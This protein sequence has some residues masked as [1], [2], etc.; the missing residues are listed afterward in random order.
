[1]GT[2]RC[3]RL[4]FLL[5]S[6]LMV[7]LI[8]IYW[9]DVGALNLYPHDPHPHPT[10]PSSSPSRPSSSS[11]LSHPLGGGLLSATM[12]VQGTPKSPRTT[13]PDRPGE[14]RRGTP[15]PPG[16]EHPLTQG[17]D[18]SELEERWR[19]KEREEERMREEEGK[20]EEERVRQVEEEEKREEEGRRQEDR[21]RRIS[22]MCSGNGTL[23]FPGKFRTFDQIPNRELDHLIVDDRHQIIYCYVPKVACTNWKRV[24]VVLSEGLLAP[25]GRPYR[26]PQALPPDLIH[27]SSLHL[28]FSKFWRRYGRLSR[29]LMR[30]KLQSY[31]KFLFVRDPFVRLISAFRNKFQQPNEDFYRQFGSVMLRRYGN[32]NGTS[33]V[34]ESAAEAF[35]AGIHPSFS[36]FVRYLLDPQT[37]QEQ[38]F[39]EHW[40]QVYRLCHPCQIQYDFIGTL[41]NLED[42]SDQLLRILGL[43]DQIK[44]PPSNRNR[45]AASWERDWFTEVP[46]ELRRKLY[47][48]YQPDFE[49][50]GYPKP[51]SLL[52]H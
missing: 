4:A 45:T 29:H 14:G 52:H 40:R 31:T 39:N 23:Q 3:F 25:D 33:R 51:E 2:S 8:I 22:D 35:K 18:S 43:E 46:A 16:E 7:L 20:R 44:F 1:M 47:S 6:V 10:S 48:L 28:T 13:E 50:F 36:E 32:G 21:R 19:G 17:T 49:L 38:P 12:E 34:P 11:A 5:G 15:K 41:E 26:D 9:D 42:D 24:M 37:E 30:V 27:N